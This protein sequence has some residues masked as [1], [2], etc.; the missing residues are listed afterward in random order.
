MSDVA[1]VQP[2]PKTE[3]D[4]FYE[5]QPAETQAE[6]TAAPAETPAAQPAQESGPTPTT[7]D[8]WSEKVEDDDL[9]PSLKGITR[10]EY[11]ERTKDIAAKA[12]QAGFQKN[13]AEA[14]ARVA[15]ATLAALQRQLSAQQAPQNPYQQ[16]FGI[17]DPNDL[18]ARPDVVLNNIPRYVQETA[19]QAVEDVRQNEVAP[20]RTDLLRMQGDM[21]R[22]VAR[23]SMGIEKETWDAITPGVAAIMA[24]NQWDPRDGQAWLHAA[25]TY[26]QQAA[27]LIPQPV[28][29]EV[30]PTPAGQAKPTANNAPTQ[31]K[32]AST[33]NKH[34]DAALKEHLE[35][36]NNTKGVKKMT[37]DEFA[38]MIASEQSFG[39]NF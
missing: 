19:R 17:S 12:H 9:P 20:L 30:P 26:K 28:K 15:E 34:I 1:A 36:W 31:R 6:E 29:T 27:R 32:T 18:L 14:R 33:G 8:F 23:T 35:V 2:D 16:P 10:K 24:A 25:T 37:L 3:M 13:E 4:Q 39:G 5:S 7:P 11:F 21:A 22:E 38:N